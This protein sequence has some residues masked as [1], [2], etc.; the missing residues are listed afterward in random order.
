V[1][2]VGRRRH[3]AGG[4]A[5]L[6]RLDHGAQPRL[7]RHGRA[8]AR[9]RVAHD[10]RVPALGLLEVGEDQLGLDRLDV[11]AGRDPAV[12]VDDVLVGV[13]AHD[14]QQRVRL[15][16]VGEELVAEPLAL[17]G[18]LDEAGDVVELDR[19]RDDVRRPHGARDRV[20]ALV[21]HRHDRDVGLDRRERVVRGLRAGAAERVEQGGLARV[22][23][24]DDPDLHHRPS[25][26]RTLPSATP[27]A[28]SDG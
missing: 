15:A 4:P 23:Q 10:A 16:D 7:L 6:Q 26:P 1:R 22:G 27:A 18:A 24:P 11:G 3:G 17:V 21:G 9:A 8:L 13:A 5:G 2:R 20:E 19:V 14:V 12:R 25:V 28:M